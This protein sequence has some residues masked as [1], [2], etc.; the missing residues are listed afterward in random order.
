[1]SVDPAADATSTPAAAPAPAG[2]VVLAAHGL[3]AGYG[4]QPVVREL[5][6]EV[7][8]GEVV[9]LL[10]ANGA[11]KTTTLLALAG[12][13][14]P[15]AGSVTWLGRSDRAPMY[16]R[17][18]AGLGFVSEQRSVISS[19]TTL[20]N[21]KLGRGE[22]D[23]ALELLPELKP[24]LSR[25]AGLLSG[26]EQ[27]FLTLGRVLAAKPKLLLADEMSLG[28]APLIV[29]RLLMAVRDAADHGVGVLIVE[30]QV[31]NVLT[32]ADRGYVIRRGS[33]EIDASSRELGE[34]LSEIEATYLTGVTAS[35][36]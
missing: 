6:L 20:E 25:R 12:V 18:R 1:M 16:A 31:R 4:G 3:S 29:K 8:S 33:I 14:S 32:V 34:R 7:R 35:E 9:A 21:L 19:L 11:G 30:Q 10:G 36:K 28:L 15:L 13:L 27:Q 24:L 26:G 5:N 17:V 22:P 2:A 23:V